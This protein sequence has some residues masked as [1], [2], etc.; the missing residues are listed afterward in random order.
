MRTY[1]LMPTLL[2]MLTVSGCIGQSADTR[3]AFLTATEMFGTSIFGGEEEG[4]GGPTT[5]TE[6]QFR[7]ALTLTLANQ[8]TEGELNTSWAAWVSPSSIRSQEQQDALLTGGYVQLDEQVRLGSAFTLVPGTFVYGGP[9]LAGATLIRL[10]PAVPGAGEN[11]APTPTEA[12]FEF[13]TPD[14]ILVFSQPPVSCDTPAFF[15]TLDGLP[16]D[17]TPQAQSLGA[18]FGGATGRGPVKTLGQF[19]AYVCDPFEPGLF[20]QRAGGA[21][22]EN[23][24]FEGEDVRIDFTRFAQGDDA[25]AA[26][27]TIGDASSGVSGP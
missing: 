13:I 21:R 19:D 26:F 6:E 8:D 20:L 16:F 15:F 12:S 10:D 24:F 11:D 18:E 3:N 22:P 23:G 27:V 5:G 17:I 4:G 2:I 7:R 14:V 25:I 9:G 1:V